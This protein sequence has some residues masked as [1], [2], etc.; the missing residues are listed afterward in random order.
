MQFQPRELIELVEA[1][2][3]F[4]KEPVL[5]YVAARSAYRNF[6]YEAAI[7]TSENALVSIGIAPDRLPETTEPARIA[8][9]IEKIDDKLREDIHVAEIIYILQA[10]KEMIKYE[11]FVK[12][13][14]T[15]DA[16]IA[17]KM[18][19]S[20]IIKYSLLLDENDV[21][22][23]SLRSAESPH[24]DL[25][26]ALRMIDLALDNA[27]KST[28]FFRLREWLHYR[29]TRVRAVFAPRTIGR[30]VA[31]MVADVPSSSLLDDALAEQLFAEGVVLKDQAAAE[32]T[33]QKLIKVTPTVTL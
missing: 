14:T 17:S 11:R 15:G 29:N 8:E 20:A 16:E 27:P 26:Q 28:P 24:R 30:A 1:D 31:A 23:P 7:G 4:S 19:K 25:R 12:T 6:D 2:A 10:A 3:N 9:A 33:F 13:I 18:I 32:A 22:R 5:R 21:G